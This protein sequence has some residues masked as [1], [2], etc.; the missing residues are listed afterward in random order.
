MNAF[1]QH[2]QL[3]Y[4][5]CSLSE[6]PYL[7]LSDS[8]DMDVISC[9]N[10]HGETFQRTRASP[11][12]DNVLSVPEPLKSPVISSFTLPADQYTPE[13]FT[14][15]TPKFMSE[16]PNKDFRFTFSASPAAL[17]TTDETEI[18]SR[19]AYS[20]V[21]G[22]TDKTLLY[23]LNLAFH[24]IFSKDAYL[25]V[26]RKSN[27]ST[28]LNAVSSACT[29]GTPDCPSAYLKD[30]RRSFSDPT[31]SASEKLR[32]WRRWMARLATTLN[33]IVGSRTMVI[34]VSGASGCGKSTL[35]HM[36]AS[37]LGHGPVLSTDTIRHILR[38]KYTEQ[39]NP[40]LFAS[41]YETASILRTLDSASNS[42]YLP[43]TLSG[44][45]ALSECLKGYLLQ[46]RMLYDVTESSIAQVLATGQSVVVE[47]KQLK[48]CVFFDLVALSY[49]LR[50]ARRCAFNR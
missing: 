37:L 13:L 2:Q 20:F 4:G 12:C 18:V 40:I 10:D 9:T 26:P 41:T 7:K 15:S 30:R 49:A 27:Q 42:V 22:I 19:K 6:Y 46:S 33:V 5:R 34:C 25:C 17:N 29:A 39:N 31:S 11:V 48:S 43:Y 8:D 45:E 38:S 47:G 21:P 35:A 3:S 16:I 50:Y 36:L 23:C 32:G 28:V 14:F 1:K 44:D 24:Y